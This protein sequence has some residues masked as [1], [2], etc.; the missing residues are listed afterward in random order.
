M[1]KISDF[2]D[3]L[4][5]CRR[6]SISVLGATLPWPF[7]MAYGLSSSSAMIFGVP[8]YGNK[9]VGRI[10]KGVHRLF[11]RIENAKYWVLYRFHPS[12]RFHIIDSGLGYGYHERDDLLLHGAMA[13]LSGYIGDCERSGVQ[14][15]GDEA[16][17]NHHWWTVTRA[18]DRKRRDNL[19]HDLYGKPDRLTWR[20]TDN[21]LLV[22]AVI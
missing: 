16:R 19:M 18:A 22:E 8:I 6:R 11:S 17:A 2:I 4:A 15:P 12:Y 13:C 7:P 5:R 20:P 3:D 9:D 14:D 21:P 1:I 10:L